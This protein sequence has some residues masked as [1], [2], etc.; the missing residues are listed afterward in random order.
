M[1][2][3]A[4][5]AILTGYTPLSP[6][7]A[8]ASRNKQGNGNQVTIPPQNHLKNEALKSYK[9]VFEI[10]NSKKGYPIKDANGGENS[11]YL[12]SKGI[13]WMG[14][15]SAKTGLVRFD[16]AA[17]NKNNNPPD[18][19]IQS[20]KIDNENI[21]W[22]DLI[23]KK[24]GTQSSKTENE[25]ITTP[26]NLTEEVITFGRP[27]SDAERDA[28]RSKFGDIKFNNI[29]KFYYVPENLEL[30]HTHNNIT[31]DFAAIEPAIPQDVLYQYKLEGYDKDWSPPTNKTSATFGNIFEGTY[32]FK[33]KA[34]S[35]YGIWS[36]PITYTFKVLPPW[37]RT[38]WAYLLYATS[39]ITALYL[40]FRWRTA[41]LRR[42]QKQLEQTVRERTAECQ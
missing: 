33:V 30:P 3:N 6:P 10:Y 17:L 15:G 14:T 35:P 13:I 32:P 28:M 11:M 27:L 42:R 39:S 19:F 4:G 25:G 2:T 9:P 8:N 23:N 18:V 21:S 40:I 26:P 1:G 7:Y 24:S 5:I 16:F 31:F 37:Y 41:T 34:Q 36:E 20:I 38:W 12:D 29:T 22:Y